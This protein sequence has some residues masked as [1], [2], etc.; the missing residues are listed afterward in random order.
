MKSFHKYTVLSSLFQYKDCK[1][2]I[3]LPTASLKLSL[4]AA[5]KLWRILLF[6]PVGAD[7]FLRAFSGFVQH[8]QQH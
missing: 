2:I 5:S 8:R 4:A 6:Q 1:K 7:G 3:L